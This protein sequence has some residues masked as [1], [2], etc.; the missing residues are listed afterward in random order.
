MAAR[1]G[2]HESKTSRI[3]HGKKRP[4]ESDLTAWAHACGTPELLPELIAELRAV[5]SA[6]LDWRRAEKTGLTHLNVAVRELYERTRIYRSYCQDVIPGL[7]QTAAYTTSTLSAIRDNR[8]VPVDDVTDAVAERM[9]RQHILY[10]GD[11]RFVF[12]LEVAALTYRRG[13]PEVMIGQLGFLLKAMALPSVSLAVIPSHIER[14]GRW[15]VE[16]F[17]I[18]DDVQANVELVSGFLTITQPREIAMYMQTF[19]RFHEIA[20]FGRQ[21]RGIIEAAIDSLQQ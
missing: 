4:T 18:F 12:I 10:E 9:A 3:E 8:E 17:Y 13:G 5:D 15:P 6:W 7:L 14:A 16:N 1:A 19:A 11:H 20:V 21:A 2:W